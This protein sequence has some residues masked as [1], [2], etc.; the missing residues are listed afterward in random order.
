MNKLTVWLMMGVFVVCA[1]FIPKVV[2]AWPE[3]DPYPV[4]KL[5]AGDEVRGWQTGM[6]QGERWPDYIAGRA[7]TRLDAPPQ[8]DII[9]AQRWR[10]AVPAA[11]PR[12]AELYGVSPEIARLY[13]ANYIV[14][15]EAWV[16]WGQ[17]NIH[18]QE[19]ISESED[20]K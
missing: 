13:W 16:F 18:W 9:Q 19:V 15:E 7:I 1:V 12:L 3:P 6:Y 4:V 5:V 11:R 8:L 14:I 20:D 10:A 17:G 2:Y